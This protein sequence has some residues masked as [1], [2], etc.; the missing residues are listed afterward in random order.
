M[1]CRQLQLAKTPTLTLALA[2]VAAAAAMVASTD[3]A[4]TPQNTG[5]YRAANGSLLVVAAGADGEAPDGAATGR[6]YVNGVDVLARLAAL[7]DALRRLE[8]DQNCTT[9]SSS[10]PC[11]PTASPVPSPSSAPSTVG[12]TVAPSPAPAFSPTTAPSSLEPCLLAFSNAGGGSCVTALPTNGANIPCDVSDT[13]RP[14]RAGTENLAYGDAPTSGAC[15][16]TGKGKWHR[17]DV[18]A[19]TTSIRVHFATNWWPAVVQLFG[20]SCSTAIDCRKYSESWPDNTV[21]FFVTPATT[22]FLRVT[23]DWYRESAMFE[24][25]L[26]VEF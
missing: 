18:P 25:R 6:V 2:L 11:A 15:T 1:R 13:Y 19:G 17:V 23:N 7:E 22:Y 4:E 24:Y 12:P 9:A 26:E 5:I 3:A 10:S 20:A 14:F 8:R 16:T 21:Q